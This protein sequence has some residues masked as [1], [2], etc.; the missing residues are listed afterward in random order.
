MIQAA[1][2]IVRPGFDYFLAKFIIPGCPLETAVQLFQAAMT[3]NPQHIRELVPRV[4]A[5]LH[6]LPPV[7]DAAE[8]A[9]LRKELPLYLAEVNLFPLRADIPFKELPGRIMRWWTAHGEALPH[10]RG[11]VSVVALYQPSSAPVE[12]VLSEFKAL[13]NPLRSNTLQDAVQLSVML[14]CNGR[15]HRCHHH[16]PTRAKS[17]KASRRAVHEPLGTAP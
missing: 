5:L 2:D 9:A 17:L 6:L 11:L 7:I 13:F 15:N 3:L 10:W 14:R 8:K 12:R 16:H 1:I 4:P